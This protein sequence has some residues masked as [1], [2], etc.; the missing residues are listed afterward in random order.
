MEKKTEKVEASVEKVAEKKVAK[1][2]EKAPEKTAAEKIWE[3]I[4]DLPID[5]F[6]LPNQTVSQYCK[7]VSIEPSKCF[8][9]ITASAALPALEAALPNI[10]VPG[11]NPKLPDMK[12]K[13]VVERVDKFVTV[14][15]SND[16]LAYGKK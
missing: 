3:E 5:M 4:R 12:P 13:F 15:Y 10:P 9:V 1:A 6:A 11:V 14:S 8:V 7:V 2:P 16:F